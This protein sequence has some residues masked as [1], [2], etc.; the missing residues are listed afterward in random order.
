MK[1]LSYRLRRC[2]ILIPIWQKYIKRISWT[3]IQI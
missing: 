1:N 3:Q 2:Q